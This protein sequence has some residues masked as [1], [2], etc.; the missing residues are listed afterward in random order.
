MDW[1]T[2][3]ETARI[4]GGVVHVEREGLRWHWRASVVTRDEATHLEASGYAAS[5]EAARADA[6]RVAGNMRAMV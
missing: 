4:E 1:Q 3:R 2:E 6:V 5:Q